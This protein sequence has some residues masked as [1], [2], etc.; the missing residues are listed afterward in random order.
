MKKIILCLFIIL[1]IGIVIAWATSAVRPVAWTPDPDAGLT[2][3]YASNDRLFERDTIAVQQQFLTGLGKGPE[4]IVIAEDG[5]LYTGYDDGRIVR[6]LVADILSA[7]EAEGADIDNIAFEEFA[8]T[9]G[10]PLGL[11][12][13]AA[14]NLIVA[15]AARGV[16]S[17][18]KQGNI[19]VLVDEYE[20]KKLLFV[21]HLD[22]ASDGT[23]WFSDA[24]AKFE[25]HDFIY[26]FL[27]ASSTGRLLSYNPATQETQVRMDNLF[28]ANGV[29]VGPND[30]FVLINET[31]RAKVHRLWLKGEKAGLRDI[32]IEQLPAMPDNLYFKD[33]IFWISLI[34]LRDPLV[35]GLA[36]NTFL[37]RIVGG[38]PK[39]LL[40]PSSHYGFVIGVSPEGKVIQNLQSAKGYQSITTA[41]EF[42]GY[43]FLGSLENSSIAVSK[44]D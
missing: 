33:G 36:Q 8:N 3:V 23:I 17:I 41:I 43:L 24:S 12:F 9:Q 6:V 42:E 31:G 18:D 1:G 29:S 19:R 26:D 16:L 27:E 13:D 20:G 39:V 35:E 4:D 44:L 38:L 28:F 15:D 11:R 30:A 10:R 37:R 5:Y 22:I 25:F 7:Y 2:G 14:G 21:D 34:T 32:F 40:K